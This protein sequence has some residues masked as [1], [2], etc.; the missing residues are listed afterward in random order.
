MGRP[1]MLLATVL[2]HRDAFHPAVRRC[3]API[4]AT[5]LLSRAPVQ[6][7]SSRVGWLTLFRPPVPPLPC[8]RHRNADIVTA[9]SPRAPTMPQ[10]VS[11]TSS[12]DA[13]GAATTSPGFV[14]P[15][16]PAWGLPPTGACSPTLRRCRPQA[17]RTALPVTSPVAPL[18]S[19][20]LSPTRPRRTKEPSHDLPP[21]GPLS[22]SETPSTDESH[23]PRPSLALRTR[24]VGPP[25]VPR[26]CRLS[27][28]SD[29]RS[30]THVG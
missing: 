26:L 18:G 6:S 25:L 20:Q 27:P 29:T 15:F 24:L 10:A 11:S 28:A 7:H 23:P 17:G 13:V 3:F 14:R 22:G 8:R 16:T 12:G 1:R 9:A 4:S 21:R 30:P 2:G 5:D 19:H